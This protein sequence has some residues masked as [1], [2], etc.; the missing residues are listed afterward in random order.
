METGRDS[1]QQPS[2]GLGEEGI[3]QRRTRSGDSSQVCRWEFQGRG[4]DS[5][6]RFTEGRR[7]H[8]QEHG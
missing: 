5:D 8:Q 6:R 7:S 4:D 3:T 1:A 2:Q